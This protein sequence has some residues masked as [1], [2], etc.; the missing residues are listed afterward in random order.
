MFA[1]RTPAPNLALTEFA[2]RPPARIEQPWDLS[3]RK[4]L[5]RSLEELSQ[6]LKQLDREAELLDARRDLERLSLIYPAL[7]PANASQTIAN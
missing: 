3:E 2:P 7:G 5:E 1:T 4:Q 6:E